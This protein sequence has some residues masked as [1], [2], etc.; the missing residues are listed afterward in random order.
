MRYLI[1]LLLLLAAACVLAGCGSVKPIASKEASWDNGV[2]DS[3]LIEFLS[4][5]SG[6]ITAHARDR[7]NALAKAYGKRF[8]P[9]LRP[10]DGIRPG[11]VWDRGPTYIIDPEH[12]QKFMLMNQWSKAH[13]AMTQEEWQR[14]RSW[15]LPQPN[16]WFWTLEAAEADGV[17]SAELIQQSL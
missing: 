9:R 12:L 17:R 10:D 4:D 13:T 11:V 16:P 7:Y 6:V 15:S 2:Q 3:G 8:S 14:V 5:G 1:L